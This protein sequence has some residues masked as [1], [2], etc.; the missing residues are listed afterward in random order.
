MEH[1][2]ELESIFDKAYSPDIQAAIIKSL[3][4]AYKV[5][6]NE[7]KH[8]PKEEA[9]DILPFY[10]WVQLRTELRGLDGRFQEITAT[11]E[12]NG[13]ASSYHVALKSDRVMLTVS[14]VDRPGILPRM[15]EYRKQYANESQLHLFRPIPTETN[16]YAVLIHGAEREDKTY[17]SF[18]QIVFPS[19]GFS[20]CIH[21]ID[22]FDRFNNIVTE[23]KTPADSADKTAEPELKR[24]LP[25][26][27]KA[28]GD[29]AQ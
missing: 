27:K 6:H 3:F 9:H 22:L 2:K 5:A 29:S 12:P 21:K 7:C 4:N 28:S 10:R 17:P 18:A 14:S 8:F 13:T 11:A 15:A 20:S 25:Q 19:V 23:I 26:V 24:I 16:I 1:E